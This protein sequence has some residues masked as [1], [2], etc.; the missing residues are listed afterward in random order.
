M[1]SNNIKEQLIE[2]LH[3]EKH[4]EGGYFCR[5]YQSPLQAKNR[6]LMSSIYYMLT[7]DHPIGHFH[8]NQSD[9]LH[10]FHLGS[11]IHYLTISPE[12][13]LESF[14]LGPEI[15]AGHTLQKLVKGGYWKASFLESGP[16]GLLSEAVSPGFEYADMTLGDSDLMKTLFPA[17]WSQIAP[18]VKTCPLKK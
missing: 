8:L 3:L 7:D 11:P 15:T 1:N 2:Q 14:I 4:V 10:F 9:I 12:G 6:A 16:F 5:T 18:Y 17:L 13:T